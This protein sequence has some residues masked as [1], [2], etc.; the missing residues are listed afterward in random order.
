ME[1]LLQTYTNGQIIKSIVMTVDN[2]TVEIMECFY[3]TIEA[4]GYKKENTKI[5]SHS[6][7]FI[8]YV[9]NQHKDVWVNNVL[10]LD[11]SQQGL[12]YRRLA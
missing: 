8:Y 11:F 5:L 1:K 2:L 6:E 7:S 10:M 3:E 12:V 9:L 4:L